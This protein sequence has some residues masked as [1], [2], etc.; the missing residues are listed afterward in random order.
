M[1]RPEVITKHI[2]Q[3]PVRQQFTEENRRCRFT[4]HPR[5]VISFS[6]LHPVNKN[7]GRSRPP[8]VLLNDVPA[9]SFAVVSSARSRRP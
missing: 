2:G 6:Q 1:M 8:I 3:L 5:R 4:I 9:P 7:S